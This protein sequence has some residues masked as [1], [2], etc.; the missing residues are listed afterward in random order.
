M[1][2][3][4]PTVR[5]GVCR[6]ARPG[7]R[8][9]STAPVG[10]GRTDADAAYNVTVPEEWTA[11]DLAAA[12]RSRRE[13][14]G[15]PAPGPTLFTAVPQRHARRARLD[16]VEAVVTA[17]LS[18][19]TRL[20]VGDARPRRGDDGASGAGPDADRGT[21]GATMP[22]D[23]EGPADADGPGG[24]GTVNVV[25]GADRAL[26]PGAL[27]DL[28]AAAVE[29]KAATLRALAGVPGTT[30]DAVAVA[31]DAGDETAAF[32]GSATPAGRAA[33]ACVRDALAAS[34]DARYDDGPRAVADAASGTVVDASATVSR[35]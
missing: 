2:A 34:L 5:E 16:G 23:G 24:P 32:A 6:L 14:A 8:W 19:P 33:R 1:T 26:A 25:V 3:F 4:E 35:L 31:C 22:S 20:P 28:L 11:T 18:N 29:A 13:R 10:G 9:L 17:G 21:R 7:S 30:T 12:A 15:F 27:A